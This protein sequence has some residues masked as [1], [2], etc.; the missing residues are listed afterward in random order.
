MK[1]HGTGAHTGAPL[2]ETVM[3]R[4]GG[5]R[6]RRPNVQN[7]V[8][9]TAEG[10]GPHGNQGIQRKNRPAGIG[11]SVRGNGYSAEII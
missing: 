7:R 2:R 6:P 3:V 5:R 9:W 10:G 11:G 4:C 1:N 8:T